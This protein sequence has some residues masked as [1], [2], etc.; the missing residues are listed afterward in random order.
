[1][2]KRHSPPQA[3]AAGRHLAPAIERIVKAN[4]RTRDAS[5]AHI[6]LFERMAAY[7]AKALGVNQI[8]SFG[9]VYE[10]LCQLLKRYE[11]TIGG[12]RG[13]ERR[14]KTEMLLEQGEMF[15]SIADALPGAARPDAD[16]LLSG[17]I[18]IY[19]EWEDEFFP[20]E[21]KNGDR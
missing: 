16:A 18:R 19:M 8:V 9:I 17:F 6:E 1:M 13:V 2:K 14:K 12:L 4:W 7:A 5:D 3:A 15:L 20:D 10:L 11:L 21:A